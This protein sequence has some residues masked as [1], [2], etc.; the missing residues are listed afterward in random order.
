MYEQKILEELQHNDYNE[1]QFMFSTDDY[2]AIL[3]SIGGFINQ[4]GL[5]ILDIRL[6]DGASRG[7]EAAEEIRRRDPNGLVVF[8]TTHEEFSLTAMQRRIEPFDYII[9][10]DTQTELCKL[11]EDLQFA[12]ENEVELSEKKEAFFSYHSDSQLY[13]EPINNIDLFETTKVP[14]KLVCRTSEKEI[15]FRGDLNVISE[16]FPAFFRG[17]KSVLINKQRILRLNIDERE[18][19]FVDGKTCQVSVRRLAE[20]KKLLS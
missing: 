7:I 14:H 9:K 18:V 17:S 20:L 6:E 19:M 2:Q 10:S 1:L 15:E 16:R 5:Y 11:A 3:D 13:Q 8:L 4:S 12:N